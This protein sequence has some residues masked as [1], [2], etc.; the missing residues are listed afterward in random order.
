MAAQHRGATCRSCTVRGLK[1]SKK[2]QVPNMLDLYVEKPKLMRTRYLQYWALGPSG[3]TTWTSEVGEQKQPFGVSRFQAI[4]LRSFG[5]LVFLS[6]VFPNAAF[7][8]K[9][10]NG[11]RSG[12]PANQTKP[13]THLG[14]P[15]QSSHAIK[16][17]LV[18]LHPKPLRRL[19][20]EAVDPPRLPP[21]VPE[22][23][24]ANYFSWS[25]RSETSNNTA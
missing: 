15:W 19:L 18:D 24:S 5:V 21:I 7:M 8:P 13:Q 14:I 23:P 3:L 10:S 22:G 2:V 25:L 6:H 1:T 20:P 17:C 11:V 9:D 4:V 16:A 12:Q